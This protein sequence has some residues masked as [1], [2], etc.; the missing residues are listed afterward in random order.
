MP[1]PLSGDGRGA[2]GPVLLSDR[3]LHAELDAE[4]LGVDPFDP[5]M[6]QPSSIDIRLDRDPAQQRDDLTSLV[7]PDG[8]EPFVLHPGEFVLGSTFERVT[9][10]DDLAGRLEGKALAVDTPIPHALGL[11]HH[12][13]PQS[14]RRGVRGRRRA[15]VRCIQVDAEDGLFLA[16]GTGRRARA[17]ATRTTRAHSVAGLPELPPGADPALNLVRTMRNCLAWVADQHRSGCHGTVATRGPSEGRTGGNGGMLVPP[18]IMCGDGAVTTVNRKIV[19]PPMVYV[20]CDR[21]SPGDEELNVDLRPTNDGQVALLVYSALDRL[22]SCC[23]PHQPWVVMP[24]ARFDKLGKHTHFDMVLLDIA[25]PDELRR[26]AG[27]QP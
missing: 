17:R 25:I 18:E 7:E 8:E 22:V 15:P 26:G 19:F 13:R 3:D 6:L 27:S 20:P 11:A 9:L 2:E 14:R 21:V 12:G 10:P 16:G 23:G 24:T 4:R 5:E 1:R